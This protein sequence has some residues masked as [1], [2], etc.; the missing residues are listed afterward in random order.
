MTG[1]GIYFPLVDFIVADS[2][3]TL[4]HGLTRSLVIGQSMSVGATTTDIGA[5]ANDEVQAQVWIDA[6]GKW[7]IWHPDGWHAGP[8]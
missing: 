5:V 7:H 2:Y 1:V 6:Q 4:T 3:G 8:L